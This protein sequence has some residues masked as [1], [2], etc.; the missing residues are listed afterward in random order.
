[1]VR[2]RSLRR[3]G[4]SR[5]EVLGKLRVPFSVRQRFIEQVSKFSEGRLR[6]LLAELVELDLAAKTGGA[7]PERSIE[8]FILKACQTEKAG[9]RG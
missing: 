6:R 4:L 7:P 9:A 5:D 8:R 1:L 2:A 3:R